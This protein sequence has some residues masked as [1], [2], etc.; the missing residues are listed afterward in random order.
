MQLAYL[1]NIFYHT[2]NASI[3][4]GHYR[5]LPCIGINTCEYIHLTAIL[6]IQSMKSVLPVATNT[7]FQLSPCTTAY[8]QSFWLSQNT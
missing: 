5:V 2:K 8:Q 6:V 3:L 7:I 1:C 4:H